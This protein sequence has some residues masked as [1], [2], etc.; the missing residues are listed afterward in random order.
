MEVSTESANQ[1]T[2]SDLKLDQSLIIH[3]ASIPH[4]HRRALYTR[5]ERA[6]FYHRETVALE[7]RQSQHRRRHWTNTHR[8]LAVCYMADRSAHPAG[9][10]R[11]TGIMSGPAWR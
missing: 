4:T 7:G 10:H 11:R 1:K 9:S 5:D 3:R 2:L 8:E 6:A